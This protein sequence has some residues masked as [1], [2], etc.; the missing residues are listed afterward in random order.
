MSVV[1]AGECSG[2]FVCDFTPEIRRSG[3]KVRTDQTYVFSK[4]NAVRVRGDMNLLDV[5]DGLQR[6][7]DGAL[8]ATAFGVVPALFIRRAL[9]V[10]LVCRWF[11]GRV[12]VFLR[13][14]IRVLVPAL[15]LGTPTEVA[16][17]RGEIEFR[18]VTHM[19]PTKA[20]N[21]AVLSVPTAT[22]VRAGTELGRHCGALIGSSCVEEGAVC[23]GESV[24]NT[25][26]HTERERI[27]TIAA[28]HRKAEDKLYTQLYT[29]CCT[30]S[31]YKGKDG[32]GI[33][34]KGVAYIAA[35]ARATPSVLG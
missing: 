14:I 8:L 4:L 13:G 35:E 30:F 33:E 28:V 10:T 15:V 32:T 17:T 21:D 5:L 1:F 23:G 20:T 25:P 22:P 2:L 6:L 12:L 31:E 29:L 24:D 3:I 9:A 11:V 7:A 34:R 16:R 19:Q 18:V 27:S 26:Q